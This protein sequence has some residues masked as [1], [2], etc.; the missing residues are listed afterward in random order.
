MGSRCDRRPS[1]EISEAEHEDD[2]EATFTIHEKTENRKIEPEVVQRSSTPDIEEQISVRP[3]PPIDPKPKQTVVKD[4]RIKKI[5]VMNI[6]KG[7]TTIQKEIVAIPSQ[8]V[9]DSKEPNENNEEKEDSVLVPKGIL[10]TRSYNRRIVSA[11]RNGGIVAASIRDSLE[12]LGKTPEKSSKSVRWD[13]LYYDDNSIAD[14]G[15]DGKPQPI[16][17]TKKKGKKAAQGK[18]Q[19]VK[20]AEKK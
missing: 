8:K 18:A 5:E 15:N 10:K 2:L 16:I 3:S 7:E 20:N 12:L 17:Q 1:D 11:G 14:F 6:Q 13:R 19:N 4:P 9:P